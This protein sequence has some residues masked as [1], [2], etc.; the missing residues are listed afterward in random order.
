MRTA[1]PDVARGIERAIRPGDLEVISA[2]VDFIGVNY[3]SPQVVGTAGPVTRYPISSAGWQQIYPRGLTDLLLRLHR[4]YASPELVITE[5]GVPDAAGEGLHDAQRI[6]FLRD[7]L[8]AVHD[9]I[10]GGATVRG[11]HAWSLMDDFEWSSGY[12]QRW[13]LVHVDFD[14][15][16]RTPKDSAGWYRQVARSNQVPRPAPGVTNTRNA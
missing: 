6:T 8:L 7:H 3:Y 16:R 2:P 10:A 15:L 13:G 14:S 11:Y 5:N 4:E 9:A 1:Q 12:T